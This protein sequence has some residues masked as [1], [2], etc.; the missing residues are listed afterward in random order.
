MNMVSGFSFF[1][2]FLTA[3]HARREFRGADIRS[4]TQAAR[5]SFEAN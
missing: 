3:K 1:Y 2:S 4:E 5:P